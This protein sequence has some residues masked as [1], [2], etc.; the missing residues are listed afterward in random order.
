M[1]KKSR[2]I[3]KNGERMF[4]DINGVRETLKEIDKELISEVYTKTMNDIDVKCLKCEYI[5][6]TKFNY[7]R[8]GN[9]K[10]PNCE[11]IVFNLEKV[12]SIIESNGDTL[13]S[14]KY[15]N[16]NTPMIIQCGICEHTFSTRFSYIRNGQGRCKDCYSK[17]N[18]WTIDTVRDLI[19]K[20]GNGDI[21]VSTKFINT[22]EKLIIMCSRCHNNYNIDLC[23]FKQGNRCKPCGYI[24]GGKKQRKYDLEKARTIINTTGELLI[25]N[26]YIN[27]KS[28]LY[29][30][31]Q[32]CN[33]DYS[34]NLD[35]FIQGRRCKWCAKNRKL[36]YEEVKEYIETKGDFLISKTY[37]R[38]SVKLNI[39]CGRCGKDFYKHFN[40]YKH[41]NSRCVSCDEKSRPI[42]KRKYT[43]KEVTEIVK[44]NGDTLISDYVNSATKLRII[45]CRCIQI[46]E[47]RFDGIKK[48][49]RCKSCGDKES[50]M[51]RRTP[52]DEIKKI[53]G[54]NGDKL[55]SE[56]YINSK[57]K[58]K[59]LC[60][61]CD[62][63]YHRNI[64]KIKMNYRCSQRCSTG[65]MSRGEFSIYEYLEKNNIKFEFQIAFD[66]CKHKNTLSFDFYVAFKD[67]SFGLIEYQGQQHYKPIE[68]FGGE[69]KFKIQVLHDN[70][71]SNYC[72]NKNMPLLII[73]FWNYKIIA[74]MLIHWF[75]DNE[76]KCIPKIN[77]TKFL[78]RPAITFKPTS[79]SINSDKINLV[80]TLK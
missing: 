61:K 46:Y 71:K 8:K 74:V 66:D 13:L 5:Y 53:V 16:V 78:K 77:D 30:K 42:Q 34:Q 59:I 39:K 7:I 67:G 26:E 36:T 15:V 24:E 1:P 4:F 68:L 12:R 70:I 40:I 58:L 62:R 10:C 79:K 2:L 52:Y 32:K 54:Q 57:T 25:S 41:K 27:I 51:H 20:E 11:V 6:V 23:H 73:P 47:M 72:N 19:E 76:P 80:L 43:Q 75:K 14:E 55:I 64:D 29:I 31:C 63:I 33:K 50:H 35:A 28:D 21:L 9:G 60:Y 48:G 65:T 37:E 45:C 56:E 69:D 38:N 17:Y 49:N 18:N 3:N 22:T 44:R